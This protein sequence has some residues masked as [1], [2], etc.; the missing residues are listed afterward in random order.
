MASVVES[1]P[2]TCATDRALEELGMVREALEKD[3]VVWIIVK[4]AE[5]EEVDLGEQGHPCIT[6]VAKELVPEFKKELL[7]VLLDFE[8]VFAWSYKDMKGLNC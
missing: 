5:R 8:D 6:L 1:Y 2:T 4:L 7:V 3:L